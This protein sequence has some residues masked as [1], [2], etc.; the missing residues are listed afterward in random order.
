M[1]PKH[2]AFGNW[3]KQRNDSIY[4]ELAYSLIC[5]KTGGWSRHFARAIPMLTNARV[6]HWDLP[7]HPP[8]STANTPHF[9]GSFLYVQERSELSL[10]AEKQSETHC[11]D[12]LSWKAF[13]FIPFLS[14]AAP[15]ILGSEALWLLRDQRQ[16]YHHLL[17][18]TQ[19]AEAET[20]SR[21]SG[22]HF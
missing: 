22:L 21:A 12:I 5:P 3:E 10:L 1:T 11:S 4:A 15:L 16:H 20:Q 18:G 13:V 14:S 9:A 2:R 8:A 6:P 19:T 7:A 17:G